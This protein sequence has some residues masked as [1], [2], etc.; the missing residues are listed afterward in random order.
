[1]AGYKCAAYSKNGDIQLLFLKQNN[2]GAYCMK[3]LVFVQ[4]MP[5]HIFEDHFILSTTFT[6]H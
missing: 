3:R 2:F 5:Y 1:M 6:C 4:S